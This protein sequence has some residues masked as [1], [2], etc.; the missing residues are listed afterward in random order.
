[1]NNLMNELDQNEDEEDYAPVYQSHAPKVAFS[2]EEEIYNKY[3]FT[4]EVKKPTAPVVE[5]QAEASK[6]RPASDISKAVPQRHNPFAKSELAKSVQQAAQ[7]PAAPVE[8]KKEEEVPQYYQRPAQPDPK[9]K[10]DEW[11]YARETSTMPGNE[12][13]KV[14]FNEDGTL[15]F[16]WID[17]HE[18]NFGADLY[19]FGKVFSP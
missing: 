19:L 14:P 13:I 11:K 15:S 3:N 7:Q 10:E 1:M 6:K 4:T 9:S 16:F 17:A 12:Q 5:E 18:E 2:K 8:A